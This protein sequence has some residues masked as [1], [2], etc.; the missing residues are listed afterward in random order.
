MKNKKDTLFKWRKH[1][2]MMWLCALLFAL[3]TI[4]LCIPSG[5][6]FGSDD[7]DYEIYKWVIFGFIVVSTV[8]YNILFYRC[9]NYEQTIENMNDEIE[10]V[11]DEVKDLK[12]KDNKGS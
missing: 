11:K 2:T 7:G 6:I 9:E 12:K 1:F 3:P 10:C 8:V 5:H 4:I